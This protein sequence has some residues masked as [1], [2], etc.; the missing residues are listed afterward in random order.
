MGRIIVV[1]L[2]PAGDEFLTTETAAL[3]NSDKA[4]WLRTLRH[5]AAVGLDIAGSFDH[6]YDS[7][8][9]FDDVYETIVSRLI[10]LASEHGEVVYAVP[11]S[12]TVAERTVEMLRVHAA[13]EAGRVELDI[14]PAMAFTDLCWNALGIDPMA[15]AAT[16]IDALELSTQIVGL[17]GPLL[18]TQVHSAEV[19]DDVITVLDDVAPSRVT[20]MKGL[21]TPEQFVDEVAWSALRSAVEP[22]HLTTLWVPRLSEPLGA[23]FTRLDEVIR[24]VRDAEPLGLTASLRSLREELPQTAQAVVVAIDRMLDEV[25]DAAFDLEDALADLLYQLASVSRSTASAGL[26]AIADLAETAQQRHG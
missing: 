18:I 5:P 16:I 9:S 15:N 17:N 1:G 4:V 21:G 3:L 24:Q 19:L 22:D 11:G 14:R 8:D 12:P 10:D 20:V 23:S 7:L 26:F 13:V 25:D 6:L 2:G